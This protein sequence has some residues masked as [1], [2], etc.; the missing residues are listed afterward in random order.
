M[1]KDELISLEVD[2]LHEA[3]NKYMLE[4]HSFQAT[5][6]NWKEFYKRVWKYAVVKVIEK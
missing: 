5:E 3:F 2:K 6:T 1:F 4:F